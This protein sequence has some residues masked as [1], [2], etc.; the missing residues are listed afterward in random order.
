M[1]GGQPALVGA[2]RRAPRRIAR[3]AVDVPLA[4]LDRLFDYEIPEAL[5]ESAVVGARVQVRFSGQQQRGWLVELGED[6]EHDNLA[7]LRKVISSEPVMNP[8]LYGLIR[9]VADHYAGT[10]AD[11]ARLAVPPRHASTEKANQRVWPKPTDQPA[12]SI[13]TSYP[14][15]ESFLEALRAGRTPRALWQCAALSSGPGDLI[16]GV[17]EAVGAT[18]ESG[19]SALVVVPTVRDLKSA[20]ARLAEAFGHAAVGTLSADAG[21]SARYRNFLAALRGQARIMVGTRSAVFAPLHD[22]GLIVVIDDGNDAH[23]EPRMP[24]PHPRS[25]AVL[26]ASR[27]PAA[28]LLAG[29]GRSTDAQGLLERGW[30]GDLTL[31]PGAARQ[32]S[33]PVR[34]V[35]ETD[36]ER[37]PAAARLRIP[38]VAFRFLR[39]HLP[40]GPVLVQVPRVG[41]SASLRCARCRNLA[42]CPK[43]SGPMRARR[44]DIVECSLCGFSPARWTCSYCH[45]SKLTTPLPGAARTAEELAR[46]FPGVLAVNSSADRIRDE[47]PDEPAIV[48]AT[49]GAEPDAPT[50]YAGVLILDADVTL[51]RADLRAA[52]EAVRRWSN[53]AAKARGPRDGGSVLIVGESGTPAVQAMVRADLASFISRELADRADAGLIPAVKLARVVGEK[54]AVDEFLDNDDWAGI[55]VLGPTEVDHEQWAALLRTPLEGAKE[56]TRR[57]KHASAIRSARKERGTLSLTVDPES[58]A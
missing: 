8:E 3:V 41:H 7:P 47:I 24:H 38:S 31:A 14:T 12:A 50:G 54:I 2:H 56:L 46:A 29:H 36:R 19:R 53:A 1:T 58:L 48:V 42:R 13:L 22:L 43:C 25:V 57:I 32:V 17:I 18:V 9:A 49:P 23:A 37:D 30:L 10:F 52:E 35:T 27:E 51:A 6:S 26:R 4:H 16:G 20:A 15:G 45:T 39:D 21:Q 5:A 33:A 40:A 44:R 55:Q 11:V 34:A 28:L